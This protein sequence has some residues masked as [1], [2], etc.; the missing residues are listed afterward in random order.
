VAGQLAAVVAEVAAST[1]L[2]PLI[3]VIR[4]ICHVAECS[5]LDEGVAEQ[6][7]TLAATTSPKALCEALVAITPQHAERMRAH[8][9]CGDSEFSAVRRSVLWVALRRGWPLLQGPN[10]LYDR[11][12]AE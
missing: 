7:N 2:A 3:E 10:D 9:G 1:G 6:L 5:T 11:V 12:S 8:K 4:G